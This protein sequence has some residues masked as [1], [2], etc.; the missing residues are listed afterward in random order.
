MTAELQSFTS[1]PS[2]LVL[3]VLD[4]QITYVCLAICMICGGNFSHTYIPV[5][6]GTYR[7]CAYIL[8]V[9]AKLYSKKFFGGTPLFFIISSK[10]YMDGPSSTCSRIESKN[11]LARSHSL[12]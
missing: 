1:W 10:K 12:S 7:M 11:C 5:H 6:A 9:Y 3:S 4:F 8:A 2:S